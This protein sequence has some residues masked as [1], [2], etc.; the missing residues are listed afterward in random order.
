MALALHDL[1]FYEN[2]RHMARRWHYIV[3]LTVLLAASGT[4]MAAGLG[5]PRWLTA[6]IAAVALF[7]NGFRQVFTP[8]ERWELAASGWAVL[9][10][11]IDRYLLLPIG[12]RDQAARTRLQDCIEEVGQNEI[13]G[14]VTQRRKARGAAAGK[15]G[16]DENNEVA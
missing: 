1:S 8:A 11:G 15:T 12:Q 16:A 13:D 4:L 7:A 6:L 10:R 9:R 2:A 5:A 3:E 14:W